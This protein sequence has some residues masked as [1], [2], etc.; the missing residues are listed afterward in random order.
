MCQAAG[1]GT[2]FAI[3][4]FY[5]LNLSYRKVDFFLTL[6]TI[7]V[8]LGIL[9]T[10]IMRMVIKEYKFLEKP[11]PKQIIYFLIV[12]VIFA[13]I[14]ACSHVALERTFDLRDKNAPNLSVMNEITRNSISNFFLLFIWN[15][16]YYT[17][18][19]KVD[20]YI[21]LFQFHIPLE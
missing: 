2:N 14:Y 11:I 3:S 20:I 7:S 19:Y 1:W 9:V 8:V 21:H 13:T 6:I 16:L 5:Y 17:F 10:H 4:I 15:L 12:T 18:H